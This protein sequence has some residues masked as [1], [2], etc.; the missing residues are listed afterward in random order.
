MAETLSYQEPQNVT[1]MD[2]LTAEEQ[3]SLQVGEQI[4]QQEEQVYAGKYK[5]AQE[6]EKAYMELQSKL[7]E[8]EDKGETEVAEKEPED[9]PTLSEGA[10]L[11]TSATDEYYANGNELSPETLQKFSSMSSQ[12]L[13][14]AYMEVQQLPE[15]QQAQQTPVEISEAQV[16][17]IKNAAGG[18]QA[19]ANIINWAKTNV[20]AEQINAFDEVVNSGSVQAIN[21]AVAGLKAQYDNANGVEGRMV[22]GKPPTNSGDVFRSQQELVAAMNDPRYD[23]DPAYRQDIIE[24]LDRSNLEF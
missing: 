2:N 9:K 14:K 1:T 16:N 11:I 7:G 20:P 19:Y 22:T 17:Q 18:E 5:S 12:D 13:I 23:R 3:D 24:K 21:L 4:S 8:Q 10:T 15:Y 6:L